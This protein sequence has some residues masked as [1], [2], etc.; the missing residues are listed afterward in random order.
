M[1]EEIS[2]LEAYQLISNQLTDIAI[3][4]PRKLSVRMLVN[5]TRLDH[6]IKMPLR[7]KLREDYEDLQE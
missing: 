4:L 3:Q 2:F 5:L 6:L 1:S 7:M